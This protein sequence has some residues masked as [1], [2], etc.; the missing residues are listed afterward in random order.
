MF[1]LAVSFQVTLGPNHLDIFRNTGQVFGGMITTKMCLFPSWLHL[2]CEYRK[3]AE[4]ALNRLLHHK[5]F[6]LPNLHTVGL[7]VREV[8]FISSE[9][10]RLYKLLFSCYGKML[11]SNKNR[12]W[13]YFGLGEDMAKDKKGMVVW[14]QKWL[15]SLH[16]HSGE[17]QKVGPDYKTSKPPQGHNSFSKAPSCV[18]CL[19]QEGLFFNLWRLVNSTDNSL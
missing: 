15:I 17:K 13:V 14:V 2:G 8:C 4:V 11:R 3:T 6:I 16:P 9:A 1:H 19:Q 7:T 18:W 5:A 12:E 10:G